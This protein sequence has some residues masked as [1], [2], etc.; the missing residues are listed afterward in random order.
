MNGSGGVGRPL[1]RFSFRGREGFEV[2]K[3]VC[4]GR[5]LVGRVGR[6]GVGA[7]LA[8]FGLT[9]HA[10]TNCPDKNASFT[11]ISCPEGEIATFIAVDAGGTEHTSDDPVA[12]CS[13]MT[14]ARNRTSFHT[15]GGPTNGNC[16]TYLSNDCSGGAAGYTLT[17]QCRPTQCSS[18]VGLK[19]RWGQ[20]TEGVYDFGSDRQCYNGCVYQK[21]GQTGMVVSADG[22][23]VVSDGWYEG[24]AESCEGGANDPQQP[25]RVP[26][27]EPPPDQCVTTSDGTEVCPDAEAGCG[28]VGG[29]YQCTASPNNCGEVDGVQ[30]CIE[31]IP[32]NGCVDTPNGGTIC[33]NSAP[34]PPV[35]DNGDGSTPAQ[36]DASF[37][38]LII[39]TG[40]QARAPIPAQTATATHAPWVLKAA[41]LAPETGQ[42]RQP[43]RTPAKHR[44]V[45]KVMRFNA[46]CCNSNGS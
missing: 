43:A 28:T 35:P 13:S 29:E 11:P 22:A 10:A 39:H 27:T 9:G 34:T 17:Q 23:T 16:F 36:P 18:A 46:P 7:L 45:V 38:R 21:Q 31:D 33:I 20:T 12:A 6:C 42:A 8:L 30:R 44:H 41:R 32:E 4:N 26:A 19:Y 14:D 37:A 24:T 2:D 3:N 15:Q 5:G 1:P 25:D 40:Q